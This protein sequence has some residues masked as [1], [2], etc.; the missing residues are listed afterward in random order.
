[1]RKLFFILLLLFAAV[2]SDA[3]TVTP[4]AQP[5]LP[6]FET[7]QPQYPP[8][9]GTQPEINSPM[10]QQ[11]NII[12][13]TY[14]R[15]EAI[16]RQNQQIINE[17]YEYVQQIIRQQ[18]F[19]ESV[20]KLITDGFPSK[21]H[22]KGASIYYDVFDEISSMLEGKQPIDL[23]KT[24]FLV[25]NAFYENSLNYEDYQKFIDEKVKLCYDKIREDKLDK[26]NNLVKNMMLFRLISDTLEV[27]SN[28]FEKTIKHYPVKY[29]LYD[30][31]S[32]QHYDSHF[33]T[34]LMKSGC[35]QCYSMPLYYLILAE[36]MEAEA[37]LSLSPNHSFVKIQDN[38]G[39]WFNLELTC[40]AI[41]SDAH[42]MNNSYI[43][44]EAI[45][46]GIFLEPLDKKETVALLLEELAG[47]YY[48][49]YGLDNFYLMC[50]DTSSKYLTCQLRPLIMRAF[51][52]TRQTLLL[53][54]LLEA[55]NPESLK[56]ISSETYKHYEE[57]HALYAQIDNLGYEE[58]PNGIYERWLVHINKLKNEEEKSGGITINFQ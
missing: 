22:L 17:S 41:L 3:Q 12:E 26:K 7:P 57:M 40:N 50:A 39:S 20:H 16:R 48:E 6:T 15:Q 5:Q 55:P 1:M 34:K 27:K 45:R 4:F 51:Y 31:K 35:G 8:I 23:G 43:K 18:Q 25:E 53:A 9:F 24:V 56:Q 13:E 52:K 58:L 30:Y 38:D 11:S 49:K 10:Q 44:A 32:E 14:A 21:R 36:K 29:D 42:Y 54:K 46:N 37:Y 33:V 28:I 19:E 2:C 47:G